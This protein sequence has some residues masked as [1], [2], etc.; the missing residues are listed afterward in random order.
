MISIKPLEE[1]FIS[2]FVKVHIDCWKETYENIFPKKVIENRQRT[3]KKRESYIYDNLRKQDHFY[4]CLYND[5]EIIGI[6]I[7]SIKEQIGLLDALYIKK[8]YQKKGYGTKL[9]KIAE[10][11]WLNHQ[12][13]NYEIYVFKFLESNTFFKNKMQ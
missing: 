11:I 4:Y 10:S 13:K 8:E 3:A 6:L 9:I 2:Q 12:I 5:F 1:V 7:F